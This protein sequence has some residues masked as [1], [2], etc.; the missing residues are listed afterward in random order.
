MDTLINDDLMFQFYDQMVVDSDNRWSK[1]LSK[2][3][4][5]SYYINFNLSAF[6]INEKYK[7]LRVIFDEKDTQQ[8]LFLIDNTLKIFAKY[9]NIE[10]LDRM[11]A[12]N[13]SGFETEIF[14][15]YNSKDG[16]PKRTRDHYKHQ[17]RNAYLGSILLLDYGFLDLISL[18]VN[19]K[20][21][22]FSEY[23]LSSA[24]IKKENIKEVIFKSYFLAALFH[25]IGY[26]LE[27]FMRKAE[28]V[29]N[30]S[31]FFKIVNPNIKTNFIEI[32]ALLADSVLFRFV[33]NDDLRQ[34]YDKNDHGALSAISF[35]LNFYY[36]GSI[37][38]LESKE[39]SIIELAAV[40]IY[41][42]TMK[43]KDERMVFSDDPISFLLR[44]CDDLQEWQRFSLIINDSHNYLRCEEC[45]KIIKCEYDELDN[46]KV[47]KCD[48]GKQFNKITQIQNKKV[49]YI[50]IC[51][52]LLISSKKSNKN[53]DITIKYD[54]YKQLE[55]L[56]NDYSAV[57]YRDK[58]IQKIKDMLTFQKY[59]PNININYFLSNNPIELIKKLV[60]DLKSKG[61][62]VDDIIDETSNPKLK[63]ELK[64]FYSELKKLLKDPV[65]KF[66]SKIELNE[67]KFYRV[68]CDYVLENMG[69]IYEIY[70]SIN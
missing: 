39:R 28:Q 14:L 53:I 61:K 7:S 12:T 43:Y 38:S 27:Y 6:N 16:T 42:H 62:N 34:K 31:P 45:Y 65:C 37:F 3:I 29:Y 49:N 21:G 66:G 51:D 5:S 52:E 58:D 1:L 54:Y 59:I 13:Y 68:A 22:T 10:G 50:N 40:A 2:N 67:T 44:L 35:L 8:Q 60:D 56:L 19:E 70:K 25:D 55:L 15:E 57:S 17:F 69:A 18:S 33:E 47:Y 23:I 36:S 46:N 41:K 63:A 9:F 64:K 48:C 24:S 32:R 26:P 30:Y 4:H 11:L 20:V